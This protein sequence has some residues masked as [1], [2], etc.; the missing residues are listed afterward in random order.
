MPYVEYRKSRLY[1]G[2]NGAVRVTYNGNARGMGRM[3]AN[4]MMW[5]GLIPHAVTMV[6][7]AEAI[8]STGGKRYP[9]STARGGET[10][11]AQ[12]F[13][14]RPRKGRTRSNPD[15]RVIATNRCYVEF[16]NDNKFAFYREFG[17]KNVKN[18]PRAL[19]RAAGITDFSAD[20][21]D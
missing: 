15:N 18:P 12:S 2:P 7:K 8:A 20:V 14:F 5:A 19:R 3:L 11:Y 1:P 9:G 6:A 16:Y 17:N 4:E 13:K 21:Y 10:P